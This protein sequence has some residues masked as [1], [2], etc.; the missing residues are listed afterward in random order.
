M[1]LSAPSSMM[2]FA[3]DGRTLVLWS[4]VTGH[5]SIL[6]LSSPH[7]WPPDTL[8][9]V[10][11]STSSGDRPRTSSSRQGGGRMVG[12]ASSS[13]RVSGGGVHS[14]SEHHMCVCGWMVG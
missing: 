12:G 10:A 2:C 7:T 5:T 3:R 4:G 9:S 13:G 11:P 8:P 1:R 6:A 14:V